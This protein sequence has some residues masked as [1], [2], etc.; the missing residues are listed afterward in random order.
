MVLISNVSH[1]KDDIYE[2]YKAFNEDPCSGVPN[3]VMMIGYVD[4][5]KGTVELFNSR[6]RILGDKEY[7]CRGKLNNE[8]CKTIEDWLPLIIKRQKE[9]EELEIRMAEICEEVKDTQEYKAQKQA[10][11]DFIDRRHTL[12][13]LSS[14]DVV[15]EDSK[16]NSLDIFGIFNSIKKQATEMFE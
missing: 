10:K 4:T 2:K 3:C 8:V 6:K 14:K 9:C 12:A 13:N 7:L 5:E 1:A 16:K 11:Q 15:V